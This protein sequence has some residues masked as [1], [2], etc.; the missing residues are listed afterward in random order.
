M[1]GPAI[2]ENSNLVWEKEE[3]S[4]TA[5][6][7]ASTVMGKRPTARRYKRKN[8]KVPS[9]ADSARTVSTRARNIIV[10]KSIVVR[11]R[12]ANY[13]A[14]VVSGTA[15]AA[16]HI[17]TLTSVRYLETPPLASI[18]PVSAA[19]L[20]SL[21]S[22]NISS[23]ES[24]LRS[25]TNTSRSTVMEIANIASSNLS[26]KLG[27]KAV[28]HR[29]PAI[30][31]RESSSTRIPS[32]LSRPEDWRN[33][34]TSRSSRLEAGKLVE[35]YRKTIV[36][37]SRTLGKIVVDLATV[38]L[39]VLAPPRRPTA[40]AAA[41]PIHTRESAPEAQCIA[42]ESIEVES[43]YTRNGAAVRAAY[44]D[45]YDN[46]DIASTCRANESP[47]SSPR[48]EARTGPGTAKNTAVAT[49]AASKVSIRTITVAN[50][51]TWSRDLNRTHIEATKTISPNRSSNIRKAVVAERIGARTLVAK[52]PVASAKR[53]VART[54]TRGALASKMAGK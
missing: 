4:C 27:R 29:A 30:A 38:L 24:A 21:E 23:S 13:R 32:S 20:L 17:A 41:H 6:Y 44:H 2:A 31:P 15:R 43:S 53:L 50:S 18:R 14:E 10:R 26:R 42:K 47:E 39:P 51:S 33:R 45:T 36:G 1:A 5:K 25:S 7:R 28:R 34:N 19:G 11:N 48:I 22:R 46:L 54:A 3:R 52:W 49:R 16:V 12:E 40:N 35:R 8:A 9:R 37:I